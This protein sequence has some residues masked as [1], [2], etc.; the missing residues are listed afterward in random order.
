MRRAVRA[1]IVLTLRADFV[2]AVSG[3]PALTRLVED[4][5]H[6]LGPMSDAQLRAAITGPAHRAGLRLEPGLVDLVLRDVEG[7]AGA[8]PVLSHALA[9]TWAHRDDRV[10]TVAGYRAG[11][12]VQGAVAATADGVLDRLSPEGR[13]IS[14]SLFLRL[15]SLSDAGAPISHRLRRSDVVQ[16]QQYEDVVDALVAARLLTAD[17]ENVE[18]A[19]EA[20]GRAWPRLRTWLEEDREGQRILRHLATSATEWERSGRDQAE[21]Y[22]GGRLRSADEWIDAATPDL[23]ASEREFLDA[24]RRRQQAEEEDLAANAERQRRANRRLR[25]LVAGIGVLLVVALISGGLFLRQRNRADAAARE[26]ARTARAATARQLAS[27]STVALD[28]DP[29]LAILLAL[30]GVESTR[31]AG[32]APLPEALSALQRATQTSR[33]LK[34]RRDEAAFYVAASAD[35]ALLATGG[36]DDSSVLIWDASRANGCARSPPRAR[37]RRVCRPV[38]RRRRLQPERAARRRR[39]RV[40]RRRR[41][42]AGRDPLGCPDR[43]RGGAPARPG[44]PHAVPG[45]QSRR[46]AARRRQRARGN[47]RPGDGVGR[48][49][50]HG[51][52][53]RRARRRRRPRGVPRRPAV[54]R[55]RRRR[56]SGRLLLRRRRPHPRQLADA[57]ARRRRR[58]GPRSHGRPAGGRAPRSRERRSCGTSGAVSSLWSIDGEAGPVRW[59]P[60]GDII[61]IAGAT[62]SPVRVVDAQSGEERMVLRGH[63]SG[64]CDVAFTPNGELA[65]VAQVSGLRL[66]DVTDDGPP[67]LRS[68]AAASG[69]INWVQFSPDGAE[70]VVFTQGRDDGTDRDRIRRGG[71]FA[72]RSAGRDPHVLPRRERRLAVR[73]DGGGRRRADRGPEPPDARA[74]G[75]DRPVRQ[76]PRVEPRTARCSCSTGWDRARPA[77]AATA[78]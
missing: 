56:R 32:E 75:R 78:G 11:G 58:H 39:L 70:M 1:P 8:L 66:W 24:S 53:L 25:V 7:Q 30:R 51:A 40:R 4:G 69:F 47:T 5:L 50:G 76:P 12:G 6:L 33:L 20:L 72:A 10:L 57:R 49:V 73:R 67:P 52:V 61:A 23:T 13:R 77:S 36:V 38:R 45:V 64:S 15:I 46:P 18:V 35:G 22:R 3:L 14:R 27:E 43:R 29:E 74:G 55:R 60:A 41:A 63:G 42:R 19:H 21:L 9:E 59:S 16:D 62:Q 31:S 71:R 48:G 17:A 68:V 44:A 2:A 54:A 65:S 37:R 34:L 28:Q 26:S